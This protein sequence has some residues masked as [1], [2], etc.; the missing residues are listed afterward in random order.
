MKKILI[1]GNN[2]QIAQAIGSK[3]E[4]NHIVRFA[5]RSGNPH[6]Y[7]NLLEDPLESNFFGNN[8]D[9]IINCAASF[10][11]AYSLKE[12]IINEEVN[13]VGSLRVGGL[14]LYTRCSHVI[15]ISSL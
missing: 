2:S 8:Y 6:L 1:V 14:A 13:S 7:F 5:G 4:E 10:L 9:V 12:M 15:N 11:P 3:L